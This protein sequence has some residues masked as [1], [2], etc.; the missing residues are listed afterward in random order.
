MTR[1]RPA[2]VGGG[3]PARRA[4]GARG[5]GTVGA[6]VRLVAHTRALIAASLVIATIQAAVL[7]PVALLVKRIFDRQ[8]PAHDTT[9]IILSGGAALGLYALSSLLTVISRVIVVGATKSSVTALRERV[10]DRLYALPRSW[11]D[12]RSTGRVHSLIVYDTERVDR[13][14]GQLL[15]QTAPGVVVGVALCVVA[16]ILDPLLFAALVIVIP[17]MFF[18]HRIIT[19]RLRAYMTAADDAFAGFSADTQEALAAIDAARSHGVSDWERRQRSRQIDRVSETSRPLLRMHAVNLAVQGSLAAS[20]AIVVLMVGGVAVADGSLSLGAL[21]A[22]YA[23][24]ALLLRQIGPA[25]SGTPVILTGRAALARIDEFLATEVSEPYDGDLVLAFEG[26]LRLDSVSFAYG[27]TSVLA[28]VDFA[29]RRGEHVAIVG[30]NGAG[31]T[32]LLSLLLGIARP[33]AGRVLADGVAFDRLDVAALRRQIG[34]VPQEPVLLRAT[35]AE[36]IAWGRASPDSPAV[37]A[38]AFLATASD[39]IDRLP[40]A[41]DTM[42]GDDGTGLSG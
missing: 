21:L 28:D 33:Q 39:F 40:D 42:L 22:Y 31:K 26:G 4:G 1:A 13:M 24:V 9:G 16:V 6:L 37:R 30:P 15:A 35:I 2:G 5:A 27:E 12:E 17:G 19:K 36:N 3:G 34:V 10:A 11:F 8:I 14:L 18:V 7:L 29:V 25:V 38:A 23:V 32:T 41:Y 20:S